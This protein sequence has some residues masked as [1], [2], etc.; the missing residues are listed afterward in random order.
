MNPRIIIVWV[1]HMAEYYDY[2]LGLVPLALVG[3]T[4]LLHVIGVATLVAVPAG[5]AVASLVVGHA[6]FVNGPV[7]RSAGTPDDT[8]TRSAVRTPINAD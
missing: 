3:I 8:P 2:V 1:F 5:A 4:A 7:D 6:L